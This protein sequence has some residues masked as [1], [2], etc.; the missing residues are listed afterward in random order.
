MRYTVTYIGPLT[1]HD[2][3]DVSWLMGKTNFIF[4]NKNEKKKTIIYRA[5]RSRPLG[6]R[7]V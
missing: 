1:L 4:D 3:N 6:S 7:A 2:D 5:V